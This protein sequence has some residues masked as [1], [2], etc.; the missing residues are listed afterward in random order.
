MLFDLD[1]L[2]A[3]R[4]SVSCTLCIEPVT[5]LFEV[6]HLRRVVFCTDEKLPRLEVAHRG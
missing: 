1:E 5:D 4:I 2:W 6:M 3:C